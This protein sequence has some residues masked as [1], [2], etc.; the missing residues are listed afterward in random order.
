M[1]ELEGRSIDPEVQRQ[2]AEDSAPG[3]SFQ[4]ET[5]LCVEAPSSPHVLHVPQ[6]DLTSPAAPLSL[7]PSVG[8]T[9]KHLRRCG[10]QEHFTFHVFSCGETVKR[11]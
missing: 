6:G 11:L 3:D 8:V 10:L 7:T 1:L 9:S 4:S 2:L 5:S